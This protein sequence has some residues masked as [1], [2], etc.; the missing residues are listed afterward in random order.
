MTEPTPQ[1]SS[2]AEPTPDQSSTDPIAP[3]GVR[4]WLARRSE[5]VLRKPRRAVPELTEPGEYHVVLQLTGHS[6]VAVVTVISE[7]TGLDFMSANQLAR[8]APAVVVT[9]VSEASAE[10]VVRR[11]KKAGARA[12]VGEQYQPR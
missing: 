3:R 9:Q 7:A 12:V 8:D 6:P 4:G 2:P 11:L 10:R 1:E 5:A